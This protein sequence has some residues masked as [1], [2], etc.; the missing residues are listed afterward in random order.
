[1]TTIENVIRSV[2]H[3]VQNDKDYLGNS[4]TRTKYV[5]I[6]RLLR[7][8]RWDT[9]DPEQVQ[10]EFMTG[11]STKKADY[12]LFK[13][14]I[15]KP[16]GVVEAKLLPPDEINKYKERTKQKN[17][18]IKHRHARLQ[19]G[20]EVNQQDTLFDGE[21]WSGLKQAHETQLKKYVHD[22]DLRAEYGILTNGNDWWI[23]DLKKYDLGNG[24]SAFA[25]AVI[26]ETSVLY[27]DPP[28]PIEVLN[29]IRRD[30][31]WPSL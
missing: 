21:V 25:K 14:G 5:I 10:L 15:E 17:Q 30:I 11:N 31:R 24:V 28:K 23:Y 9:E 12:V 20:G 1:M 26:A 29:L 27:D 7:S 22:L 4:E 16:A 3:R 8:L 19:K 18:A 2:R 6:D 13:R